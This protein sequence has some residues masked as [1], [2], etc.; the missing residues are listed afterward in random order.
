[1]F[2]GLDAASDVLVRLKLRGLTPRETYNHA[3][4]DALIR[5]MVD[6]IQASLVDTDSLNVCRVIVGMDEFRDELYRLEMHYLVEE[7][8]YVI[9][10]PRQDWLV[11]RLSDPTI[12]EQLAARGYTL[13]KYE[14]TYPRGTYGFR[15]FLV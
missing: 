10:L 9:V 1:M 11:D 5:Q 2:D 3:R 7:R 15:L 14:R 4:Q 12:A 13:E 8:P 6:K